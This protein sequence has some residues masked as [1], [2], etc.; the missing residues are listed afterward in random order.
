[1]DENLALAAHPPASLEDLLRLFE[2]DRSET[3]A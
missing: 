3:T 2:T 1:V